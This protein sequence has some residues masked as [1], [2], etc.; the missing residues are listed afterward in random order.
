M[1]WKVLRDNA[2]KWTQRLALFWLLQTSLVYLWAC[3]IAG[4]PIG[5][6]VEYVHFLNHV[7]QYRPLRAAAAFSGVALAAAPPAK[8]GPA[9]TGIAPGPKTSAYIRLLPE[10]VEVLNGRFAG[11]GVVAVLDAGTPVRVK[12]YFTDGSAALEE[13]VQDGSHLP[14]HGFVKYLKLPNE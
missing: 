2:W 8:T 14:A 12:G 3:I 9:L 7:I 5:P 1:D 11:A 6:F 10:K 13:I 4:K